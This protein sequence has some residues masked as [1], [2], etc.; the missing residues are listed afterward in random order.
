LKINFKK[1][2]FL[3]RKNNMVWSRKYGDKCKLCGTN[4]ERHWSLGLCKKCWDKKNNK[5]NSAHIVNSKTGRKYFRRRDSSRQGLWRGIISKRLTEGYLNELYIKKGQ[6]LQDIAKENNCTR[7]YVCKLLKKF[8]IPGRNKSL[9]RTCAILDGKF[10]NS[11]N[12]HIFISYNGGFFSKWT[13]EMAWI[14]GLL[15]SDGNIG[16]NKITNSYQMYFSQKDNELVYKMAK[17]LTNGNSLNIFTTKERTVHDDYYGIIKVGSQYKIN[18]SNLHIINDLLKIGLT[19]NKSY[20]MKFPDVPI[21]FEPHFFRGCWEGDGSISFDKKHEPKSKHGSSGLC[22]RYYTS[23]FDFI[24]ELINRL[25]NRGFP[26]RCIHRKVYHR[27]D[28]SIG[29]N[30]SIK[31]DGN[32]AMKLA[33]FMYTGVPE[34]IRYSVDY[35]KII[36]FTRNRNISDYIF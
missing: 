34:N 29:W 11:I 2:Y 8:K 28:G 5:K 22:L 24:T 27:K 20:T 10:K 36:N 6:S 33:H 30:H 23:S 13:S 18:I 31:F 21:Q 32:L 15:Y 4:E 14:L 19:P 35:D 16:L 17:L 26:D 1:K 12:G 25:K 9:A 7:Q 3:M